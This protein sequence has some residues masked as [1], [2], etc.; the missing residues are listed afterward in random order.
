[1]CLRVV[2]LP[3]Q[4]HEVIKSAFTALAAEYDVMNVTPVT[5]ANYTAISVSL[6]RLPLCL[7]EQFAVDFCILV[8]VVNALSTLHPLRS[9]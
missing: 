7:A 2:T 8:H 5:T 9:L 6:N 1:M 3:A 4:A